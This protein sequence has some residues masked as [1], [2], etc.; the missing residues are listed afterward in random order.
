M[1]GRQC[2]EADASIGAGAAHR[3]GENLSDVVKVPPLAGLRLSLRDCAI[4]A[5]SR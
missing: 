3:K 4:N 2:A 5:L 1:R